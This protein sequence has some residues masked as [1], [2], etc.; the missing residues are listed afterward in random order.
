MKRRPVY[1]SAIA[2]AVLAVS[3][4]GVAYA[5]GYGAPKSAYVAPDTWSGFY[6]GASVGGVWSNLNSFVPITDNFFLEGTRFDTSHG[7]VVVGGHIGLQHQW[8]GIVAGVELQGQFF[9]NIEDRVLFVDS[10]PCYGSV[11]NGIPCGQETRIEWSAQVVGR[12]GIAAGPV[13]PY[14][15]AG[16]A[17]IDINSKEVI[18][19]TPAIA[20]SPFVNPQGVSRDDKVH[21]GWV[22]GGGVEWR[23]AKQVVLGIDYQHIFVNEATHSSPCVPIVIAPAPAVCSGQPFGRVRIDGDIDTVSARI[24]FLFGRE[25]DAKPLK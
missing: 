25:P 20:T 3:M 13:L 16:L 24:S 14:V 7:G 15:K 2:A 11:G 18:C 17:V 5:D 8:G 4:G 10:P 19:C 9:N 12:L 6:A 22:A 1:G 21:S 23:L